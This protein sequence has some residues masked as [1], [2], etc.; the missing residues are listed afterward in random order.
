M[1]EENNLNQQTP[2]V[3]PEMQQAP[4][5]VVQQPEVVPPQVPAE[6][7]PI[8]QTPVQQPL[9]NQQPIN[10]QPVKKNSHNLIVVIIVA[11][12]IAILIFVV[13]SAVT[14]K[15]KDEDKK[16]NNQTEETKKDDEEKE[17]KEDKEEQKDSSYIEG[18]WTT[19]KFHFDGHTY[20]L[21]SS[22]E[23][24]TKN[25]WTFDPNY[26][27]E[28]DT[29]ESMYKTYTTIPLLNSKYS[30]SDV[31]V[32]IINKTSEAKKFEEC[33]FWYVNISNDWIDTPLEFSLPGGIK[34]GSTLSE[35]EKVYGKPEEDDI[36]RSETLKY[37]TYTYEKDDILLE[38]TIY[39][40]KGLTEFKYKYYG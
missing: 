7:Q 37:Y 23:E 10:N 18:D 6:P 34:N 14:S 15:S 29:L 32:A 9:P 30:D 5:P 26:L 24:L 3:Q 40:E 19:M 27:K 21:M 4:A 17:D 33:T 16:D 11:V 22:V 31:G 20:T 35:V 8:Q 2:V 25:G 28:T 12:V 1:N 38:L 39:D 36:Y 13:V